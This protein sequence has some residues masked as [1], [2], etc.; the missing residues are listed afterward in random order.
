VSIDYGT[1]NPMAFIDCYFYEDVLYVVDEYYHEGRK[2]AVQKTNK[3]YADDFKGFVNNQLN[4]ISGN[5]IRAV[6]IDPS[7]VS[8][9]LELRMSGYICKEA[10]NEVL[11]GIQ[12][13]STMLQLGR[14][15]FSEKCKHC[16][17]ELA[18]YSWNEKRS[19]IGIDE[20]IKK[21]D[22]LMDALRYLVYTMIGPRRVQMLKDF[23]EKERNSQ[24]KVVALGERAS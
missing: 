15:K 10:N 1:M 13:V 18:E 22:H 23:E 9:K 2:A 11:E 21:F 7:A 5:Q 20:P 17:E 16:R 24:D 8:F 3:Q 6:L 12:L 14:I 19:E 4:P